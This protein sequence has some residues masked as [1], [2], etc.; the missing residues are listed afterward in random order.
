MGRLQHVRETVRLRA[1][2]GAG[3]AA[4]SIELRPGQRS[5]LLRTLVTW[6]LDP[7]GY[8]P[9][10]QELLEL[11]DALIAEQHGGE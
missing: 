11:R 5:A 1:T 9:I 2:F 6:V 3:D 4:G 10:P 7:D 8:E